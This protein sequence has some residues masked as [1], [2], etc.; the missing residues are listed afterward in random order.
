MPC[1]KPQN[2][3]TLRTIFSTFN[4]SERRPV[5]ASPLGSEVGILS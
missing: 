4:F 1:E 2:C 3:A 5:V